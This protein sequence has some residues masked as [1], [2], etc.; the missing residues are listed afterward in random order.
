MKFVL[1]ILFTSIWDCKN[2]I[3]NFSQIVFVRWINKVFIRGPQTWVWL[4]T[5]KKQLDIQ[6]I[7]PRNTRKLSKNYSKRMYK[8]SKWSPH[9][10]RLYL[11]SIETFFYSPK[12]FLYFFLIMQFWQN[13]AFSGPNV[14]HI[15]TWNQ[16]CLWS[17]KR[18]KTKFLC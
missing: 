5:N 4:I 3:K 9:N 10:F 1:Y 6:N 12:L 18:H 15:L 2:P 17:S 8:Y 16:T 13:T 14:E 7:Y 11:G